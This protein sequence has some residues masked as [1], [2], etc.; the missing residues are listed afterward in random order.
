[1]ARYRDPGRGGSASREVGDALHLAQRPQAEGSDSV[2]GSRIVRLSD[3]VAAAA[4]ATGPVGPDAVAVLAAESQSAV[5]RRSR[6]VTGRDGPRIVARHPSP[7]ATSQG[8]A[9]VCDGCDVRT[10]GAVRAESPQSGFIATSAAR[11][12]AQYGPAS[13]TGD[14]P[15]IVP[16]YESSAPSSTES[17]EFAPYEGLFSSS[18][19]DGREQRKRPAKPPLTTL[20]RAIGLLTRREHSRKELARKLLTRGMDPGEVDAAVVKLAEAGWQDDDRFAAG[21]VRFRAS[22]G[23]GPLHIR[24]ELATHDLHPVIR[25]KAFDAFEDDWLE[26]A[27]DLVH[28]RFAQIE[29]PR[30]RDRKALELLLRRGFP[31]DIA[32]TALAVFQ[33]D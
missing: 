23:Y 15:A 29:E 19:E 27:R 5:A 1:M 11:G 2:V 17:D 3:V 6:A 4:S 24:A 16:A 8:D 13:N 7:S 26:L 33:A 28:R 31:S 9:V 14:D 30:L 12:S 32:R 25:D 21:L 22:R 18:V 20:Q 10:S